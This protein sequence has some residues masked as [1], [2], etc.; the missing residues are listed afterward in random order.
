MGSKLTGSNDVLVLQRNTLRS[1]SGS[2]CVHDAAE[3]FWRWWNWLDWRVGTKLDQLINGD[4]ADIWVSL[5][6]E[7][8]VLWVNIVLGVVD[9]K[10][11][12]LRLLEWVD[13]VWK[14]VW[15]EEDSL[16]AGCDERVLQSLLAKSVVCGD[17]WH[18]LG[19]SAVGHAEPVG[20]GGGEDVDAVVLDEAEVAETRADSQ[21]H[22]LV[23]G[24][25]AVAVAGKLKVSPDLV[26]LSLLAINDL[27]DLLGLLV[28]LD[29]LA[30]AESLC[31]AILGGGVHDDIEG[32]L[33]LSRW[34]R[35]KTVEEIW[36]ATWNGLAC[37]GLDARDLLGERSLLVDA[38]LDSGLL[39]LW[40]LVVVR[41]LI[42]DV[43]HDGGVVRLCALSKVRVVRLGSG[44]F[45]WWP[46]GSSC[47]LLN[48]W[49]NGYSQ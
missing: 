48:N 44:K 12:L 23:V 11:D 34:L 6:Q 30:R 9:N 10:L 35:D 41:Q 43:R 21:N 29:E 38:W 45:A 39:E 1:T 5:V 15:V 37:S 33:N 16:C 26:D 18:G 20:T 24:K 3:V 28:R 31:V 25:G 13:D 8:D 49:L 42:R 17:N 22:L 4:N 46:N 27:L 2:G 47:K 19:R 32:G 40:F 14:K 36:V 7:L